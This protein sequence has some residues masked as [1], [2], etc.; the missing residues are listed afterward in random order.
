M[1]LRCSP[2]TNFSIN[3]PGT[4]CVADSLKENTRFT[5]SFI[6]GQVSHSLTISVGAKARSP[7][8]GQLLQ[9]GVGVA[10]A[11]PSLYLG[12]WG[13][14]PWLSALKTWGGRV[15]KL[16]VWFLFSSPVRPPGG[17]WGSCPRI[18]PAREGP[19]SSGRRAT[20]PMCTWQSRPGLPSARA[21]PAEVRGPCSSG[22]RVWPIIPVARLDPPGP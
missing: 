3:N 12:C 11:W 19:P 20:M 18:A 15:K 1:I 16:T 8:P 9:L 13:G 21:R 6:F 4:L 5:R 14:N 10:E 7:A 22:P 17:Q 2:S